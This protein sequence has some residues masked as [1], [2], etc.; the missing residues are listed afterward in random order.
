MASS[1]SFPMEAAAPISRTATPSTRNPCRLR[2]SKR[3]LIFPEAAAMSSGV[4]PGEATVEQTSSTCPKAPFVI[5][6]CL[7][8][9]ATRMLKRL[10]T[11][12]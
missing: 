6:R 12:S 5:I 9:F 1:L 10:R 11:K 8:S 4:P 3:A 2:S 7:P